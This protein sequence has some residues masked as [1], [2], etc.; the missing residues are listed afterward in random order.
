MTSEL[1]WVVL[2]LHINSKKKHKRKEKIIRYHLI[3][4]HDYVDN[5]MHDALYK[6][7]GDQSGGSISSTRRSLI[8][9]PI[10]TIRVYTR[11]QLIR[12]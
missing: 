3:S 5:D 9:I 4:D 11:W 7:D 6:S 10:T 12:K 2:V 8:S 1:S